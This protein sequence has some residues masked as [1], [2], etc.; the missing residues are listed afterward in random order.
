MGWGGLD[1]RAF[2]RFRV[3]CDILIGPP[4]GGLI[5]AQTQNLGA[6]GVCIILHQELEKLSTVQLELG[7]EEGAPPIQCDGR[8]VWMVRSGEL[9]SRNVLFD[10]GIEFVNLKAEDH[11]RISSFIK[12]SGSPEVK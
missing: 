8:V 7:L 5:K 4:K 9:V 11:Q 10:T 12:G 2:P 1:Q 6:G 3:R